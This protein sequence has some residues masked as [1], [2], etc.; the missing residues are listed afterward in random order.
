MAKRARGMYEQTIAFLRRSL[1]APLPKKPESSRSIPRPRSAKDQVKKEPSPSCTHAPHT[2]VKSGPKDSKTNK[3][4]DE[5]AD[6]HLFDDAAQTVRGILQSD[7]VA[8]VGL[9]D[10]QLFIRKSGAE[11]TLGGA[12]KDRKVDKEKVILGFTQGKPWPAG[13]DPVV[14]HVPTG[15]GMRILGRSGSGTYHFDRPN[16]GQQ[17]SEV[18]RTY[19]K[20]RHFW[21]DREEQDEVSLNLMGMMPDESKTTLMATLMTSDGTLRIA[22]LA[23]W[24]KPPNQFG[25]YSRM[26]LPFAWILGGSIMAAMS[27]RKVRSLEQSQISYS[28]LQAH[29]LR[30]P[31]HQILAITQILRSQMTDLADTPV[32]NPSNSL[33]TMQQVRDLLPMLDAI[34]TS[35][36]T[37]HGIVDNILSFLD[38]KGK[39][40]ML[41]PSTPGLLTSPSGAAESIEVMFEELIEEACEEDKRVRT[42]RGQ[43]QSNVET[44][45]EIIPPLLGE[46]VT[47]DAGGALRKALSKILSN[48]YKFI[49]G[50]GCVEIYVDDVAYRRPPEGCEDLALT[51]MISITIVDSGK[52]MEDSFVKEKLGEPWAKEDPFA[53]GSGLSVHLAWRIIDLMGGNMEISSTPGG[54]CTVKIEVPVPRR[55]ISVPNSPE[56]STPDSLH[57]NDPSHLA[58]HPDHFQVQRQVALLGYDLKFKDHCVWGLPRLGE[59]LHHSFVKLGCQVTTIQDAEVVVLDGRMEEA[60]PS[61]GDK[62]LYHWLDKIGAEDI[63][64]LV[65]ADHEANPEVLRREHELGKKIRRYRKPITPTILRE[66]LFPGHSRHVTAEIPTAQ[67]TIQTSINSPGRMDAHGNE[68]RSNG[69]D[70]GSASGSASASNRKTNIHFDDSA[71]TVKRP[72]G[73][74]KAISNFSTSFWKP[75]GMAVEEAVASLCLGDYFSSRRA[76]TLART[77]SNTSSGHSKDKSQ[78]SFVST[79]TLVSGEFSFSDQTS[80]PALS[81]TT[82]LTDQDE[83]EFGAD[84]EAEAQPENIK[85]M[86]VEDNMIN[87]KILVKILS[88]KLSIDVVEAEDGAVAVELFREFTCPVI[89]KY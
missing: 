10:F 85:V 49:E 40:N 67:G 14:I 18:I 78:Y 46:Q 19:I 8:I 86:V 83:G 31:L 70:S 2:S 89:G 11:H 68:I 38:L 61:A 17:F 63:V 12:A 33:T 24:D 21:W 20:T 30:T 7:S 59:V 23:S 84:V 36:K 57:S 65:T 29:E 52:G 16:A 4:R 80:T 74:T 73:I 9:E 77:V 64:I 15:P 51:N 3:E 43:G 41:T 22:V 54:G 75:K 42:A 72:C 39:D 35:G 45:F 50:Q 5:L 13:V 48:A 58:V 88:S 34:D 81:A 47:E 79:P 71:I 27:V 26:A 56:V 60:S 32:S 25:D 62:S 37:L 87:R 44:I 82:P 28:N 76:S 69:N 55:K 1:I 66:I 6:R 53:T